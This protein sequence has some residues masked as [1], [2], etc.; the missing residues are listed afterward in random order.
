M[1]GVQSISVPKFLQAWNHLSPLYYAMRNLAPYS[2]DGIMF[3][4][5]AAQRLPNGRCTIETGVQ[6]LDLYKL[7]TN[8]GM[9]LMA[10]GITTVV[11]RILAYALLKVWRMHWGDGRRVEVKEKSVKVQEKQ[12][13]TG[14]PA[15]QVQGE[16]SGSS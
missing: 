7:N 10:L 12:V 11:Y 15:V 16:K 14:V 2:L 8:P 5:D 1:S 9:N 3:T 6:A 13:V 4:C